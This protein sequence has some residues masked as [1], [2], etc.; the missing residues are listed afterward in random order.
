M[1]YKT[2]NNAE[3]ERLEQEGHKVIACKGIPFSGPE[4]E[5]D[6]CLDYPAPNVEIE[7]EKIVPATTHAIAPAKKEVKAKKK[8]R[9]NPNWIKRKK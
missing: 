8:P 2:T 5:F 7:E 3:K 6:F 4:Y 1:G 9:G